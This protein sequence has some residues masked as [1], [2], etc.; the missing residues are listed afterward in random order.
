MT[1]ADDNKY[2]HSVSE[3]AG[4][5]AEHQMDILQELEKRLA[6]LIEGATRIGFINPE[7]EQPTYLSI[8]ERLGRLTATITSLEQ[9]MDSRVAIDSTQIS[10]DQN[11]R[12]TSYQL[13]ASEVTAAPP[14][15]PLAEAGDPSIAVSPLDPEAVIEAEVRAAWR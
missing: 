12:V 7:T 3:Q 1:T 6:V 11:Q 2:R 14:E 10:L 5:G 15:E 4:N 8:A 13:V 9:F